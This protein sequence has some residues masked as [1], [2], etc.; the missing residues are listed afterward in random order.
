MFLW[1]KIGV[2]R[3]RVVEWLF[4]VEEMTGKLKI[5]ILTI[6]LSVFGVKLK[7]SIP[8]TTL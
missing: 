7:Q 2:T 8:D 5:L 3:D 6:I 1:E 4:C